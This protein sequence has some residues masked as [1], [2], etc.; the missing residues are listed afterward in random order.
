MSL[1]FLGFATVV[2]FIALIMAKRLSAVAALIAIPI[3]AGLIAGA[4]AGL[5]DM[6][7]EGVVQVAPIAVMLAFAILYFGLMMDAGL[8]DP[9]VRLILRLVGNDPVRIAIGTAALS[10]IVSL[11]GD[12]TTTVL[13]V[14]TSLLPVYRAV[15]MNPLI[16]AFLLGSTNIIMNFFPW[17]GPSA[18]A[19]AALDLNLV[20]DIFIPLLPVMAAGLI[21][22]F[23]I[24]W[25][26][27]RMERKRLNWRSADSAR[28]AHVELPNPPERRPKLFWINLALSLGLVGG[29][30]S[31]IAPLPVLI[32]GGFAIALT[33]NYPR[34]GEQ[35]ERMQHHAYNV[36][37]VVALLFAAGAFTG[38]LGGTGMTDAMA[39][40]IVSIVPDTIGPYF[41]PITAL[42]SMP[43]TFLLSNDAYFFG[44]VPI[45][46]QAAGEFGVPP[47]AIARASMLGLPLHTLSPLLAPIYLACGLLNVEVGD[48]QRFAIKYAVLVSLA[49]TAAALILGIIPLYV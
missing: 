32:M 11:D 19:A 10:T 30:V 35:K 40:S 12:G 5:G 18:R 26:L 23:L 31:G 17:G 13:I 9:L 49:M 4:G 21:T 22:T 2:I 46:A 15:G 36:V 37:M 34:L 8:F 48:A 24:A 6:M 25:F 3:V 20:N 28:G 38:I 44:V 7:L 1:A 16:L 14:I 43:L 47:E 41:A 45:L 27:G 29:M 39:K 33:I 42:L